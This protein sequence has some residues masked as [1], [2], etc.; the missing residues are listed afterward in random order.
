S[1]LGIIG[2]YIL[3]PEIFE[4]LE[5]TMPGVGDEIQLTDALRGLLRTQATYAY[6]FAGKRHDVG[7]KFDYL[8]AIV[9]FGL[10][11][12]DFGDKFREHL[13]QMVK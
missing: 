4:M 5:D 8:K 12:D 11:R 10:R 6:E 13:K 9:E 3:T 1:N 2:R 7:S